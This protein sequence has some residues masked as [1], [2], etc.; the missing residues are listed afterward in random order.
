MKSWQRTWPLGQTVDHPAVV[1]EAAH[2]HPNAQPVLRWRDGLAIATYGRSR[3]F[4]GPRC[5]V[6]SDVRTTKSWD[7]VRCY[8]FPKPPPAIS[9]FRVST[10]RRSHTYCNHTA[11]RRSNRPPS[12]ASGAP[13]R[14]GER[15]RDGAVRASKLRP[16]DRCCFRRACPRQRPRSARSIAGL[17]RGL[18][19]RRSAREFSEPADRHEQRTPAG[20]FACGGVRF[21]SVA[22]HRSLISQLYRAARTS[23]N[24]SAIV[25]AQGT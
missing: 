16:R 19:C 4:S 10:T 15:S 25:S 24:I 23:N 2:E 7:S 18:S 11:D 13:G 14:T 22:R 21:G 8:H 6:F 5:A 3:G 20:S 17:P 9:S 1:A 12:R